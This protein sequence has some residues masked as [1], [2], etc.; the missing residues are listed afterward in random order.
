MLLA[1]AALATLG[2]GQS[3]PVPLEPSGK[4]AVDYSPDGCT[5]SRPFGAGEGAITLA[6]RPLTG[7]PAV[8]IILIAGPHGP[9]V[10]Q[11]MAQVG[12]DE[13]ASTDRVFSSLV[14][15][16]TGQQVALVLGQRSDLA[17]LATAATMR[18]TAGGPPIAFRLQGIAGA[19]KALAT[20]EN[21]LAASW[22][23][24]PALVATPAMPDASQGSWVT[25]DDYPMEAMRQG[26]GGRVDFRIT[27]NV[28]GTASNCVITST[29]GSKLLDEHTCMLMMKRPHF[30]PATGKD[31]K[32]IPGLFASTFNWI[33]PRN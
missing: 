30:L 19:L 25:N 26:R 1:L 12:A 21:A 9:I 22:G 27:V 14:D 28:D 18:I 6:L 13:G 29:S 2:A 7:G 3:P 5:L 23:F 16:A 17:E 15:K 10:G 24:D 4:W 11:G 32:P 31:G 8:R 33:M 20:C